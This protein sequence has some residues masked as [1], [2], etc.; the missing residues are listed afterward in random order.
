MARYFIKFDG[1]G[2]PENEAEYPSLEAA[3]NAAISLLG[4]HLQAHPEYAYE[5]HWRVDVLDHSKRLLLHV[6]VATVDAPKP[7]NWASLDS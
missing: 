1:E 7:L 2:T 5:R 3:R 6:I 4:A